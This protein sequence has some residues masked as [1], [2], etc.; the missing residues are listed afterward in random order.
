MRAWSADLYKKMK[1]YLGR[2]FWQEVVDQKPD[3]DIVPPTP[4]K[5]EVCMEEFMASVMLSLSKYEECMNQ[6][7]YYETEA[8]LTSNPFKRIIFKYLA[9]DWKR[10]ALNLK[11]AEVLG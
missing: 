1:Q 3:L 4:K 2:D 11:I 5:K 6:H 9:E 10:K 8:R 7:D